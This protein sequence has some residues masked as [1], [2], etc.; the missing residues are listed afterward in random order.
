[1]RREIAMSPSGNQS[2]QRY[3]K[4]SLSE[5]DCAAVD[6]VYLHSSSFNILIHALVSQLFLFPFYTSRLVLNFSL[7]SYFTRL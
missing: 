2:V 1:M 4:Q 5:Q 7:Y 3:C 6:A